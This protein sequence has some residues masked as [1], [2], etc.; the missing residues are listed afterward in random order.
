[1]KRI[2]KRLINRWAAESM[3]LKARVRLCSDYVKRCGL[4]FDLSH[5]LNYTFLNNLST[6]RD[7]NYY[8]ATQLSRPLDERNNKYY[9]VNDLSDDELNLLADSLI[10]LYNFWHLK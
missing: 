3:R 5:D 2:P 7:I 10:C 4:S 1:M 8:Y 6:P 9:I